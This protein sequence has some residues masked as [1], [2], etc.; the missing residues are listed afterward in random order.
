MLTHAVFF[1]LNFPKDSL[2]EVEFLQAAAKLT[3]IPNVVNFRTLLQCS[4]KNKFEYGLTMEF[5]T[6]QHYESYNQH[7]DHINFVNTYWADYVADFMEID[8]VDWPGF[9]S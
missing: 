5:A 7:A 8:Y 6:Q 4:K 3:S 9:H 2:E 1:T